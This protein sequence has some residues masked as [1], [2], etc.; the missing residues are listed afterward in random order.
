[1]TVRS[2]CHERMLYVLDAVVWVFVTHLLVPGWLIA[3]LW[4]LSSA[5][6]LAWLADTLGYGA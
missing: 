4:T 6:K 2:R 3:S 1:M 5:S